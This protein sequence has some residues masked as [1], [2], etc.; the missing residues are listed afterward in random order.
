MLREP[1]P[2]HWIKT[3]PIRLQTLRHRLKNNR[4]LLNTQFITNTC[5]IQ[6]KCL[7]LHHK[8][9]KPP[10]YG[11]KHN[12]PISR[13]IK[14]GSSDKPERETR[15]ASLLRTSSSPIPNRSL[16]LSMGSHPDSRTDRLRSRSHGHHPPRHKENRP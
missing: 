4:Y 6:N 1:I 16:H 3:K 12:P 9:H 10:K 15:P 11:N 14:T 5:T 13:V 7:P 2:F 8:P